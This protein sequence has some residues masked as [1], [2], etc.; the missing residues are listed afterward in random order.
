IARDN[1]GANQLEADQQ[2]LLGGE[3]SLP[4]VA[5]PD[6]E[7]LPYDR[8]SP[9]PDIISQRLAALH[10]LPALKRGLVIVPVQTLLQQLAPR[11]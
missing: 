5:F 2:T 7:T 6:W 10:R 8:F 1:H 11:S 4:V 9:H 3:P